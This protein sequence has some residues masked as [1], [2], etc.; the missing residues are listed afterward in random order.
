VLDFRLLSR[1]YWAGWTGIAFGPVFRVLR[2]LAHVVPIEQE[3]A[4]ASSL[5]FGAAV[6]R[7]QHN[8]VLKQACWDGPLEHHPIDSR[9]S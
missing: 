3:K 4:A 2:R 9:L 7:S 5:A 8:L 6:L 1:T